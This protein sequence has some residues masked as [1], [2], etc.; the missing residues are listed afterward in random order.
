M[1]KEVTKEK[2]KRALTEPTKLTSKQIKT[3]KNK[4]I[5]ANVNGKKSC[6]LF[7]FHQKGVENV[8]KHFKGELKFLVDWLNYERFKITVYAEQLEDEY[9]SLVDWYRYYIV[10][11][12]S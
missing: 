12:W 5:E 1:S 7:F 6:N 8:D 9:G 10:A 2:N 11:N 3:Y 4:I